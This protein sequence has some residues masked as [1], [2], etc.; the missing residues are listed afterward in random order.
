MCPTCGENEYEI[1]A[2]ND[3]ITNSGCLIP[4]CDCKPGYSYNENHE[5]TGKF[6]KILLN[7]I[8]SYQLM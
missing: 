2:S 1:S 5:C 6:N 4:I 3:N 7:I 8:S